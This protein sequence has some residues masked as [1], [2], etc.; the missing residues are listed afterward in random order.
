M[1]PKSGFIDL[2]WNSYPCYFSRVL[3]FISECSK[4]HMSEIN[5]FKFLRLNYIA[6]LLTKNYSNMEQRFKRAHLKDKEKCLL[7]Q[8]RDKKKMQK[9]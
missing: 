2:I 7:V 9:F 4:R 3:T 8:L 5:F 1:Q 6:T